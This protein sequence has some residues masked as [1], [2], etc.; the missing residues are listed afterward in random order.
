VGATIADRRHAI[1]IRHA[2]KIVRGTFVVAE[3]FNCSVDRVDSVLRGCFRDPWRWIK[4]RE[5]APRAGISFGETDE[6]GTFRFCACNEV[7]RISDIL[8][9]FF[10]GIGDRL[11][12][13]MRKVMRSLQTG[14]TG[15][16]D[17]EMLRRN[18]QARA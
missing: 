6:I 1:T 4:T 9:G 11:P 8:F 14:Y 7:H 10:D 12:T 3:R 2:N 17:S 5:H 13:A 16:W 15:G 18:G